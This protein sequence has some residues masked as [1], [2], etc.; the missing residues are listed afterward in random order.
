MITPF[1]IEPI[2]EFNAHVIDTKLTWAIAYILIANTFI[3][4]LL[5]NYIPKLTSPYIMSMYVYLQP[6]FTAIFMAVLYG[7]FIT[8]RKVVCGTA[9]VA[10]ILL[11]QYGRKQ[12]SQN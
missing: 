7:E 10:G 3:A 12:K 1:A 9:V 2:I 5:T 8:L 4:Y 6:V 11:A